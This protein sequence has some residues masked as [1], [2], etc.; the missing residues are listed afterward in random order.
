MQEA[1]A[2]KTVF[3]EEGS[4]E[5]C[6]PSLSLQQMFASQVSRAGLL[7]RASIPVGVSH[8]RTK[9]LQ[10]PHFLGWSRCCE[11]EASG[12]SE[13]WSAVLGSP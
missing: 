9:Q 10:R 7:L 8:F 5:V 11:K 12:V 6:F 2:G 13:R 1:G 3:W 4:S